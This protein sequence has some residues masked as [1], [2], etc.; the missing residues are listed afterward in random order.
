[1]GVPQ[2]NPFRFA[3]M[4]MAGDHHSSLEVSSGRSGLVSHNLDDN[5]TLAS[6]REM[7][8]AGDH[9]LDPIL[10]TIS[11]VARELTGASGAALAMWKDS[12]MVCRARSGDMAPALGA[13][14]TAKTG[15][16][17]ECLR[18]GK[19]KR[20]ADTENDPV[21]DLEVCRSLGLRSI[22]VAPIHGWRGI[23]GIL[24]VFSTQPA[25][26]N[27]EHIALLQELAVLAERAR[28]SQPQG[29]SPAER[30]ISVRS[31]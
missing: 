13:T 29:A 20:C 25:A 31:L 27:E 30:R 18:T 17:G 9:G 6:V 26:F 15:I 4:L 28:A 19:T 10:E 7:I 21:V 16:S 8:A 1:V 3:K 12:A 24:E 14:L 11:D 22:A 2:S 5:P 23:N